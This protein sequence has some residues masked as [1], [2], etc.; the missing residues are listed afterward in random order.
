LF[1]QAFFGNLISSLCAVVAI[2]NSGVTIITL[3]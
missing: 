3:S 2:H 1:E